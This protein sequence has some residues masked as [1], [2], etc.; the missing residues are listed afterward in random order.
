VIEPCSL[1]IGSFGSLIYEPLID[2]LKHRVL[3]QSS[4]VFVF[5]YVQ[6]P[7]PLEMPI[8]MNLILL[9]Q[10]CTVYAMPIRLFSMSIFRLLLHL[11]HFYPSH[12]Y[13]YTYLHIMAT[14]RSNRPIASTKAKPKMAYEK[15][16]P[17]MLGLRATAVKR[18]ANTIPI[19]IP[20]P[21][22]PM[23]AEP[24]PRFWETWTMAVAISD[25]NGRTV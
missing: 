14:M 9:E 16:C 18:A 25:E 15:S 20:A 8:F 3:W 24:I 7:G 2:P 19:P 11:P 17:R 12:I 1:L 4:G 22:R 5:P 23:A 13:I 6:T 10:Y 21:P